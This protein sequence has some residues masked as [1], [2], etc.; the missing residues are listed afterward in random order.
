[1]DGI[2]QLSFEEAMA[3]LS[4]LTTKLEKGEIPLADAL[5]LYQRMKALLAHTEQLLAPLLALG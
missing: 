5:S 4:E 3:E 1:M 2:T